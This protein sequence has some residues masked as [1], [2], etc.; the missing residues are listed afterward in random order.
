LKI[1]IAGSGLI[2]KS[3]SLN[4]CKNKNII[5][6]LISLRETNS[7]IFKREFN[8]LKK[9]DVFLDSMDPNDV[10]I[11]FNKRIHDKAKIFREYALK[12]SE[13]KLYIY[14]S[15]CNLYKTSFERID[16]SSEI[17]SNLTPY[18][19]MKLNSEEQIKNHCKSDFT[20]LRIVNSWSD[21]SENSF[22]GDLFSA[23]KNETYI[24]PREN[25]DLVIS[26]ANIFDI[27]KIIESIVQFPKFGIINITT[28]SFDSRENLKSI[29]NKKITKPISNNLGYRIFSNVINWETILSKKKE[30]F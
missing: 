8:L 18:L 10:N 7:F 16:E 3:L 9:G 22:L 20:I 13:N 14:L 27:C 19:R 17:K 11:N 4:I 26:Y 5:S 15:T 25:D 12:N 23:K 28:N 24:A 21:S 30:L 6:K 29:V 1:L 2:G